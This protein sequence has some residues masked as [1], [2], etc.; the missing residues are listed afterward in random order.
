MEQGRFNMSLDYPVPGSTDHGELAQRC[1][2]KGS[3]SPDL[4]HV[5]CQKES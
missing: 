2:C 5:K 3:C 4:G 1:N